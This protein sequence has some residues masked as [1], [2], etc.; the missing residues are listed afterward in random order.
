VLGIVRATGAALT[1]TE[2]AMH[3]EQRRDAKRT[4]PGG[5]ERTATLVIG[6][7]QAGLSVGYHLARLGLPFL[8]VDA[9]ERIGD[10]W[11]D[12]WDSLRLFTPARFDGLDGMPFPGDP[13]RFPTKDEVA[14]YL[15]GY[16]AHFDL[17]VRTGIRVEHL[18]RGREGRFL[19]TAG[20][21][22]FEADQVVVAMSSYQKPWTPPFASELHPS[23][24]QLHSA[25]YRS[26]DQLRSGPVLLVGAGN[27]GSEIA[28]EL[29]ARHPV[30]MS[31]RD[32]GELPF[33]PRSLAG[34]HVLGPLVLRGL[35]HRV[36]TVRT[37]IGRKVR[38][39]VLHK[40][41]PLIRVKSRDMD[42]AGVEC[43]PKTRGIEDGLPVLED[44]RVLQPDNVIW[45][46]G[47]RPGLDWLDLPSQPGEEPRHESGVVPDEPGLYFVG[48][49]FLHAMS[50]GMIHGVGR[51]AARIAEAIHSRPAS[52]E[53]EMSGAA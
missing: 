15:E 13:H 50:S 25:D 4:P 35:F 45:C 39:K 16:A 29:A 28:M 11:R 6:G 10:A 36:L 32:V 17:P 20:A 37:P 27:S 14:D 46:T 19:A 47:F 7:G 31:G 41:G 8:I 24:R 51:D 5:R 44:G 18:T 40:G 34:R 2:S 52:R 21:R 43:M 12:R 49:H 3:T 26:P 22:T 38:A 53:L 23:I 33:R 30:W 48:Q 1:T 9:S 42:A